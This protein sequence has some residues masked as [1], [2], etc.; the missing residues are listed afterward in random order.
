MKIYFYMIGQYLLELTAY[1]DWK[2]Y[3]KNRTV[4]NAGSTLSP[5]GI[6][7]AS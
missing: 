4:M 3:I 5:E 7:E 2:S 1:V 6:R